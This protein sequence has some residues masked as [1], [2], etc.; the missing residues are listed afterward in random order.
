MYRPAAGS[1]NYAFNNVQR[2]EVLNGPQG[3][4]FGRNAAGGVINVITKDPT[5]VPT[6]DFS[7]GYSSY[8][9]TTEDL[10]AGGG[11]LDNLAADIAVYWQNQGDGWGTN[12]YSH[13]P[14]YLSRE[15]S[16][17]SKWV[18]QPTDSDK[19]TFIAYYDRTR[20]DQAWVSNLLPGHVSQSGY[21]TFGGFYDVD[22]QFYPDGESK[23]YGGSLKEDHDFGWSTFTSIT[24]YGRSSWNGAITNDSC[25]CFIQDA[26]SGAR[27]AVWT[28][29]LR[30][31]SPADSMVKWMAGLYVYLDQ[32]TQDPFTQYGTGLG[33]NRPN[34][35]QLTWS[36]Q[37]TQSYAGFSKATLPVIDDNTD[38]TLG[39][40]YTFDRRQVACATYNLVGTVLSHGAQEVQNPKATFRIALD[41]HFDEST[42]GYISWNRGFKSGNFNTNAPSQAPTLPETL[43]AYE[44]GL[45]TDLLNHLLRVDTSAFFYQFHNLQV[46]QQLIT[47]TLQTNAGA[48]QYKGID[49]AVSA[50]P[51]EH[52]TLTWTSELLYANYTSFPNAVFNYI[53]PG[54]LGFVQHSANAAGYEIPYADRFTSTGT[55]IYDIPV[56]FGDI[57]LNVALAYHHG[58][59]FDAQELTSQ[60]PYWMLNSSATWKSLDEH[61]DVK[62]WGSN[63]LDKHYYAQ[64]QVSPVGETYSPAAPR[65]LGITASYH[66]K[67]SQEETTTTAYTPPPPQAPTSA[68]KVATSYMVFFDF[69]KSDL[70]AQA[71][72]I[73]DTAA[74]VTQLMVTG[75]TDT[76]GSDA[77]NMRL[78]RRRA[79]SVAA[80]LEKQGI[81]ASEIEIVAKGKHDLLVPT[82][83]GVREPQNRRVQIVFQGGLTS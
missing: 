22:T 63:L 38:V 10:Y 69:N 67:G 27:D 9:T 75:H 77:Y 76:V 50:V 48:A 47:G 59:H 34:H 66:F 8:A 52:L 83:D 65:Y 46:Q 40:R 71:V 20:N 18:W 58:F 2:V 28:Q 33:A 64:Q 78:S 53:A 17:R 49:L 14:S 31:S 60:P 55:A 72:S 5:Q 16:L 56:S 54:G 19:V 24:A 1:S 73:V 61:W 57:S 25:P 13:T 36:H 45:K 15:L 51:T 68:P 7:T 62:V 82:K 26:D 70:T 6:L 30:L 12:L 43:D 32:A 80:E 21:T 44:I 74:K 79:E 3:T 81:A 39:L 37:D 42:L 11:V 29:E 4:L 23:N 41:H 35:E